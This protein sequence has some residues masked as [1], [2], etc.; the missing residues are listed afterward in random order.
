M[1]ENN[2]INYEP[3]FSTKSIKRKKSLNKSYLS[4]ILL[5][6][7]NYT[8]QTNSS[9]DLSKLQ[10]LKN[11]KND[12]FPLIQNSQI[13][14]SFYNNNNESNFSKNNISNSSQFHLNQLLFNSISFDNYQ[15]AILELK[16]LN[17][18]KIIL[19][20]IN[21]E[22]KEEEKKGQSLLN[23]MNY[24]NNSIKNFS[25]ATNKKKYSF[26]LKTLI[27][28]S[29]NKK[30]DYSKIKE[31]INKNL[32]NISKNKIYREIILNEYS[33][34]ELDYEN[35]KIL[36]DF[37]YYNKWLK[38]KLLELKKEIPPEETVNKKNKKEYK[39]SK[40]NKPLL[41]FNSLSISFN[42][43]G[44]SHLFH[45]P[46]EYL[47]LFYYKNM[48]YLKF[49]LASI[50]KFDNDFE[51]I[52]IDFDEIIFILS[53]SKQFDIKV[54]EEIEKKDNRIENKPKK[55]E[56]EPKNRQI[57]LDSALNISKF[58]KKM[59]SRKLT[60]RFNNIFSISLEK[61]ANTHK[62]SIKKTN[63]L[64]ISNKSVS[65]INNNII[66][67]SSN[68]PKIKKV[69]KEIKEI[70]EEE[71]NLYKCIYN[72][73]IFKWN[74]PKYNYDVIV[75]TP[76]A[77]FQVGK[78]IFKA[79][80]DIELIFYLLRKNYKNWD[81]YISQFIF[82]Y[83][84]CHKNIG[85]LLS[86][87]S[88]GELF[89]KNLDVLPLLNKSESVKDIKESTKN[90]KI[91]NLNSEKIQHI[92]EKSKKYEFL[93]TDENNINYIK[94]FHNFFIT[95]RCNSLKNKFCFDFNF[96]HMRILNKILRI[97]GLNHFFKKLI[98]IDRQTLS[99]KF[100]YDELSLLVNE[101][102]ILENHEPNKS[103]E[104]ICLRMKERNKD[105][106][107]FTI[108][109]PTLETI[110]YN[111]QN[112]ENCFESDY[113]NVIFDG[114]PLNILDELCKKDFNEWSNVLLKIIS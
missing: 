6:S 10:S 73:F 57:I 55:I 82:S 96:Y 94:I 74:T 56:D 9:E 30:Y 25:P 51:D 65:T 101:E 63:T 89:P 113:D 7:K 107:N 36:G 68:V 41:T 53:C 16:E 79:Y 91:K 43:K 29:T 42:C 3:S 50:I 98:C 60:N 52:Y 48:N 13:S 84:E 111:N 32:Y 92:S 109:F 97:Q 19:P 28:I 106:I 20:P 72:K 59:S 21:H 87:K 44:K 37:K 86:I 81:F 67:D 70:K 4:Q 38:L 1:E 100:R 12:E 15:K 35:E 95:S 90:K 31:N 54:D 40:Y 83:K 88:M 22:K 49:I 99:L 47:P 77:I 66:E 18:S 46:F 64:R 78:T 61:G 103:C 108:S 71:K 33:Y 110:K 45:I 112:Y 102:Y 2:K 24:S 114:I 62:D 8:K 11:S 69:K 17:N 27:D 104:Q 76:E 105:I 39:N 14:P 34:Q 26:C 5:N 75:K 93:Y 23:N 58:D 80:I 85:K